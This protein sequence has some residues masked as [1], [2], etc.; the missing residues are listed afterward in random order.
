MLANPAAFIW[1]VDKALGIELGIV[2][3]EFAII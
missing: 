3:F 1:S 2:S